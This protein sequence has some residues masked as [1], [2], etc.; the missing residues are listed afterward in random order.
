MNELWIIV[1]VI[2]AS[3]LFGSISMTRLVTKI[4][5]P[6]TDIEDVSFSVPGSEDYHIRTVSSTTASIK[7]GPK[8]GGTIALLDMLKG[9]IPVLILRLVYPDNYYHL[10]AAVCIV[11]GHDWSIFH[12]FTGG[13]G[14]STSYGSF[15]VVD[16]VGTLISVFTGMMLGFVVFRDMMIA[17]ASGPLLFMIWLIIFKRDWPHII[18]G[19]LIN[20]VIILKLTPDIIKQIKNRENRGDISLVM[21]Q[22]GMGRGMK[23]MMKWMGLDPDK[24]KKKQ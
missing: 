12:H 7:L 3:Y 9:L 1:I 13:G 16:L 4:V 8:V 23:K 10:I 21:D 22:T 19:I 2:I 14:L 18:F 24:K 11:I 20:V 6:E 17:F 15:F 5:S